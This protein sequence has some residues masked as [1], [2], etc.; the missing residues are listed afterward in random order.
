MTLVTALYSAEQRRFLGSHRWGAGHGA[1]RRIAAAVHDRLCRGPRGPARRIRQRYTAKWNNAVR[2][3]KVSVTVTDGR[4]HLVIYGTAETI[5]ADA[6]RAELTA[7]V[8]RRISDRDRPDPTGLVSTLDEAQRTVLRIIPEK[9]LLSNSTNGGGRPRVDG[10]LS[11][12]SD[13]A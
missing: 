9:V 1:V 13:G 10:R 12:G 5:D 11:R 4:A 6:L 2:N 3:P 7:E 8:F